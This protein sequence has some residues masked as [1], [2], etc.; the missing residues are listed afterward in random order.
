VEKTFKILKN[1]GMS[2]SICTIPDGDVVYYYQ[3]MG[4]KLFNTL[5]IDRTLLFF[6]NSFK[7]IRFELILFIK[8]PKLKWLHILMMSILN[9]F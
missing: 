5:R 3:D 7:C 8:D 1:K 9:Q 6:T 4:L 2:R